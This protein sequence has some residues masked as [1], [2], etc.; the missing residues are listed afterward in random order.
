MLEV[1]AVQTAT[2]VFKDLFRGR[3][4]LF[5]LDNSAAVQALS[6]GAAQSNNLDS[7]ARDV[8]E[9]FITLGATV[10]FEHIPRDVNDLAD[11]L[12]KNDP[13]RF[14]QLASSRSLSPAPSPRLSPEGER[15]S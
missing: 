5:Q 6:A 13:M 9:S 3:L 4:V 11:A 8:L 2:S 12:S 14:L 10:R 1:F 15:H 7:A